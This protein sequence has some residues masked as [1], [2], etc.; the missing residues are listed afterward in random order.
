M[1]RNIWITDKF[2]STGGF[3]RSTGDGCIPQKF[4]ENQSQDTQNAPKDGE[5]GM[6]L[7]SGFSGYGEAGF[8]G[9][10]GNSLV[11]P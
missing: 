2:L 1:P 3:F 10:G 7:P 11:H 4:P 5:K 9:G 6:D 8:G